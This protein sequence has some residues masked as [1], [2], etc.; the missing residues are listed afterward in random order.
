MASNIRGITVEIGGNTTKLDKALADVNKRSRELSSEL[1]QV[2]KLL[3]MD[4]GNAELLAQKQK[5]LT[6]AISETEDKLK[7]LKAA[8]AQVQEQFKRGEVS[9]AQVR[10][11]QREII[12]TT[13][14]LDNYERAAKET[15]DALG[16]LDKG[17][18]SAADGAKDVDK[19]SGKASKALDDLADKA[20]KAEK[21]GGKL[22]DTLKNAAKVGIGAVATAATAVV[23][24][25]VGSA[26][27]TREYRTEMGKLNTAFGVA[28]LS[29]ES[30]EKAYTAL[31]GV[32]GETDQSV[33]A[34]QQIA[35]L[36]DSEEDV[37]KWSELA[38][39]VVGKFGDALQPETFFEAA[40][41]TIKLGEATGAF[42]QALEQSG[43]NVEEFNA[44]LAAC[45]TEEERQAYM[46]EVSNQ[47]L[48]EASE[49]YR[50][51][52]EE[53]IRANEANAAW[54]DTM[55][56][57]GA[58]VE[59]ILT[60]VKL[61]ATALLSDLLPGIKEIT[62][63]FRG[64]LGGDAGAAEGLG[65]S[66]AGILSTLLGKITELAPTLVQVGM[67]LITTLAMTLLTQ[68][69]TIT[70]TL[71]QIFEQAIIFLSA[72]LPDLLTSLVNSIFGILTN[73]TAYLPNIIAALSGLLTSIANSL[74]ALVAQITAW[75]PELIDTLIVALQLSLPQ[76]IEGLVNLMTG[77]L[78][79]APDI[80]AAILPLIPQIVT[81]LLGALAENLPVILTATLDLIIMLFTEIIPQILLEIGKMILEL[82]TALNDGLNEVFE[83][84]G[85]W[86]DN[87][88]SDIAEWLSNI[89]SRVVSWASTMIS[90]ARETGRNFINGIISFV[91][92]LPGKVWTFLQNVVSRIVT[93]G[94]NA[95]SKA[96]SA[97]KNIFDS[98]VNGIKSLPEKIK[99]IGSDIVRGLWNGISDMTSWVIGKIQ[100]FG[101]NVL[102]GIKNF[103]GI[104]SP[105]RLMRDQVGKYV[106]EG[107]AAG[108]TD[109]A[110]APLDAVK[111]I[112]E[113]LASEQIDLNGATINRKLNATFSNGSDSNAVDVGS[114]LDKLDRLY[115][116]I[117]SLQI[118]LDSGETV[119][120]LIDKIDSGLNDRYDKLARGW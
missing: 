17:T 26:E 13:Q 15:A 76:I 82:L 97:A 1:T 7:T 59:P 14:K 83:A 74:P 11:L 12:A 110:D 72:A 120:A 77:L 109:N 20:D 63:A 40:N 9:E 96:E 91:Q 79:A 24:A 4:P 84:V 100:G 52:N 60:D 44:G 33:E 62:S 6:D 8:E 85:E 87:L 38:A 34:A 73:F 70:T 108:I 71:M 35:L 111:A 80:I 3:K 16:D 36:A 41:E 56:E 66:I 10:A 75:L 92:Q 117:R 102:S 47:L 86:W 29:T 19:N 89:I 5:I 68:L 23:G 88:I 27:A 32:I 101:N 81:A 30:A 90:K 116:G 78:A 39:G 69:P 93:F 18:S 21:S 31:Y 115:E 28:E 48:G 57:V 104:K 98:I 61:L 22:G 119:G 99:S 51:N 43:Y 95:V 107:I 2:N 53:I 42:T 113:D 106:A 118:V 49:Q 25:L 37:A 114:I 58:A 45:V 50:K 64:L 46:L 67:S 55:A 94:S 112:G 54:S 105:S 65:A 103:F